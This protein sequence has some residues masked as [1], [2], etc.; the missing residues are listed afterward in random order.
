MPESKDD[1]QD[2]QLG[3]ALVSILISISFSVGFGLYSAGLAWWLAVLFALVVPAVL[4]AVIRVGGQDGWIPR[5]GR[6]VLGS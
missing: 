5:V 4:A 2:Y 6:W 3:I 1:G